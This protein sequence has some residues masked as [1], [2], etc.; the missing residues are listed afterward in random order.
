MTFSMFIEIV[1]IAAVIIF[2]LWR[3]SKKKAEESEFRIKLS[4][5]LVTPRQ[6]AEKVGI[7]LRSLEGDEAY[8]NLAA[9]EKEAKANEIADQ[10]L[11]SDWWF[12]DLK[13]KNER[14]GL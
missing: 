8:A 9:A 11:W 3:R 14:M 1:E 7:V 5:P 4:R 2:I 6:R 13:A 10:H 12:E